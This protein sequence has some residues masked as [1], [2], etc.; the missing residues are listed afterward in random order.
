MTF[1]EI[2]KKVQ[3]HFN[4]LNLPYYV[5]RYTDDPFEDVIEMHISWGDW[6]HD[7][8]CARLAVLDVVSDLPNFINWTEATTESDGS[9]CYSATH[10]F[11]FKKER[12]DGEPIVLELGTI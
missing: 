8:A 9:D 11:F 10:R 5:D 2:V 1:C 6:K 4:E 7:H 12:K 3:D